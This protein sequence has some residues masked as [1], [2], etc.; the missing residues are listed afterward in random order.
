[1]KPSEA[2]ER[3]F[4]TPAVP[5]DAG[6]A[7]AGSAQPA[8]PAGPAPRVLVSNQPAL[9]VRVDGPPRLEPVKGTKLTHVAN[10]N[11]ILLKGKHGYYLPVNGGFMTATDLS[12]TWTVVKTP[13]KV[14]ATAKAAAIAGGQVDLYGDAPAGAARLTAANA[15]RVF[16]ST[17]PA[18]LVV[19]DGDPSYREV[20]GTRLTRLVNTEARV[21]RN[22]QDGS[23]YLQ[24]PQGWLRAPA[25]NGP[26]DFVAA[27]E[28][29]EGLQQLSEARPNR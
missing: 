28:L 14:L 27:A 2:L 5:K 24:S 1:M 15:P 7:P 10:T 3:E 23:I 9:L 21:Y 29:P 18:E 11:A 13:P 25:F 6:A 20:P 8:K 17:R 4:N 16:V 26:W 22:R 12:G 19:I